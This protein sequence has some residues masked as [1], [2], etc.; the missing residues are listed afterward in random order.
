MGLQFGEAVRVT[1]CGTER[2]HRY[3]REPIVC[4]A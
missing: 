4:G 1:R 2:L 3:R